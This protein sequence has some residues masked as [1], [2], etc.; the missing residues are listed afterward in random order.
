MST[1]QDP[2]VRSKQKKRRT[3]QLAAWREKQAKNPEKKAEKK[4]A[5]PAAKKEPKAKA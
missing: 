3:K 1:P 4:A 2:A 5:A